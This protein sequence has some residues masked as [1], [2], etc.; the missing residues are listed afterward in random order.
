MT[1]STATLNPCDGANRLILFSL[2]VMSPVFVMTFLLTLGPFAFAADIKDCGDIRSYRAAP[3]VAVATELQ[4]LPREEAVARLR[5]WADSQ[6]YDEQVI[7]LCRMLFERRA[8]GEFRRPGLGGPQFY[9]ETT[10]KDW[11]LEPITVVDDVPFLIV[12]GYVL[13]GH[14]EDASSYLDYCLAEA[15]WARRRYHAV[16]RREI[17]AALE[18][19]LKFS[20]WRRPLNTSE[21]E[22][23][24][25]QVE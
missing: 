22:L 1:N 14:A 5:Q 17:A 16:N 23:L 4:S 9:G 24:T 8:G 21:R 19:L 20:A 10:T 11:P 13:A 6:K 18:K 2:S 12:F 3:Y 7:I 15:V 25:K